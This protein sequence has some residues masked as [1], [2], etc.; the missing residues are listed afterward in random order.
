MSENGISN[1]YEYLPQ[2]SQAQQIVILLH[3]L[4]SNGQDLISLAPMWAQY[5][6][7]AVFVS[8]DAPFACDMAPPGWEGSY[9]WYSLQDRDPQ[10]LLR[11]VRVVAPLVEKFIDEQLARFDLPPEKLALV[12]FSQGTMT[13]LYVAP[14][15]KRAI[16]GVLGYS[17]SLP[18][19]EALKVEVRHKVP[20]HLI[21]GQADDV[22]P[23]AAW[24]HA[25]E[26]L[27]REGFPFSGHTTPG[28]FHNIDGTGIASGGAFLQKVLNS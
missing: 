10:V 26:I 20:I 5:L 3:G 8:P 21:H 22:V 6:P 17:G 9:Q 16:A 7:E 11:G 24:G 23:V 1:Y 25:K 4:G 27:E 2:S 13:S 18:W 14:R 19:D 28:L 12:G 15:L